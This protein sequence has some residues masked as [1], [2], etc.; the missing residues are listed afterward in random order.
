MQI[1]NTGEP[2]RRSR[3][4]PLTFVG[5]FGVV[6]IANAILIV[7]ALTSWT[8][9]ETDQAYQKGIAYNR[10][11][12]TA[13]AQAARGWRSAVDFEAAAPLNG[14]L[15]ASFADAEG[16]PI[17][18][19]SVTAWLLRPTHEGFDQESAMASVGA[20][21]YAVPLDFPLAGQWEVRIEARGR[22][23]PYRLSKRIMVR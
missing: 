3:W 17:N 9:L 18:G 19:L 16:R 4:I 6:L 5:G 8:G 12:A 1:S 7:F 11:L 13:E 14:K 15:I 21:R 10:T 22:D 20:G 2:V 23:A